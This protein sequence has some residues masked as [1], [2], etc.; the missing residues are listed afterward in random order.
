MDEQ[1]ALEIMGQTGAVLTNSHFVYASWKH[2][3]VYINKDAVYPHIAETS[4][5]CRGIAE[6]FQGDGIE[7]VVAPAIG[8]VILSQWTT[9]HLISLTGRKVLATYA[10]HDDSFVMEAGSS[11]IHIPLPPG[12][13][14]RENDDDEIILH[15]G[16]KLYIRKPGFVIKR[17]YDKQVSGKRVLVVEDVLTTGASAGHVVEVTRVMGGDVVGLGALCNR[18]GVTPED[19]G[20]VPKLHALVDVTLDTWTEEECLLNGPCSEGVPVN[21]DVGKGRE[22][23]ACQRA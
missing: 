15:P 10:E 7:V 19:V 5:L 21:T 4:H 12:T 23:L 11:D 8:G 2:G 20:G 6:H 14:D 1:Y 17:G 22:F 3:R 18:G 9:Q 16:E 13:F